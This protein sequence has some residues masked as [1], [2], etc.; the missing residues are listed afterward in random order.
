MAKRDIKTIQSGYAAFAKG[1]VDAV[2]AIMDARIQWYEPE[3]LPWGG[4]TQGPKNVASNV[5]AAAMTIPNF[6]VKPDDFLTDGDSVVVTGTFSG[7]G[8][9]GKAFKAPFAHV[10]KV[11]DGK[12][13]R[14]QNYTDSETINTALGGKRTGLPR[15]G[16]PRMG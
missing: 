12:A 9:N 5:F 11:R 2:L 7:K 10:W 16:L 15:M 6:K 8:K 3:T 1:D 13:V 4:R 14:F